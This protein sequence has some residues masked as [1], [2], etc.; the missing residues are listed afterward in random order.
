M[1]FQKAV[2]KKMIIYLLGFAAWYF[3]FAFVWR[4]F[5]LRLKSTVS[6]KGRKEAKTSSW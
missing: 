4:S 3:V 1:S 6:D 5:P 2:R